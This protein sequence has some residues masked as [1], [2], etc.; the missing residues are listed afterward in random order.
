MTHGGKKITKIIEELTIYFFALGAK[1]IQSDIELNGHQAVIRFRTDYNPECRGYLDRLEEY[2]NEPKNEGI[3]DF[4]WELAGSGDPGESSQLLLV[5][6]MVEK[7]EV[8]IGEREV[9]LTLYRELEEDM[10]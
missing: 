1:K 8:E 4:Y 5:G 2:L 7:A 9:Y 6:M 3:E 10:Y